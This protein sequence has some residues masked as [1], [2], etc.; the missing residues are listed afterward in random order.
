MGMAS[1]RRTPV[2][3]VISLTPSPQSD[4]PVTNMDSALPV[5]NE[6]SELL[7][8]PP[9]DPLSEPALQKESKP[10]EAAAEHL[11]EFVDL[12]DL[13]IDVPSVPAVAAE[14]PAVEAAF[15][16]A[17]APS[18]EPSEDFV[19]LSGSDS[20]LSQEEAALV[21]VPADSAGDS[22]APQDESA[23]IPPCDV[24]TGSATEEKPGALIEVEISQSSANGAKQLSSD[25]LL[26]DPLASLADAAPPLVADV[27]KPTQQQQQPPPDLFEDDPSDLFG[28]PRHAKSAKQLPS[29]LFGEVDEDIFG[30][31]LVATAKKPANVASREQREPAV[32]PKT[33]SLAAAGGG[34]G[35]VGGPLNNNYEKE[36][37]DI[38]SEEAVNVVPSAAKAAAAAA[39]TASSR[40][41]GVHGAAEEGDIFAGGLVHG[42]SLRNWLNLKAFQKLATSNK[43]I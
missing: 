34:F 8:E 18:D 36:P 33:S 7:F 6:P 20:D 11:E 10:A 37:T 32:M 42:F 1:T 9:A 24:A 26:F 4:P 13:S 21:D 43:L 2:L 30:E 19:D 16:A 22:T 39:A 38:F 23:A 29:S 12:V 5:T 25:D 3:I 27:K 15:L 40:T 41:N 28:E 17:E 35:D 31:P 14:S